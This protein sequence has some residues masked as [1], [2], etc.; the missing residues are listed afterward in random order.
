MNIYYK[1]KNY[2]NLNKIFIIL[3]NS[4]KDLELN[5]K[6]LLN[7]DF[8]SITIDVLQ[9]LNIKNNDTDEC[10]KSAFLFLEEICKYLNY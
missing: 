6:I 8:I 7:Y 10:Y 9:E 3:L 5:A 1:Y 4:V 2:K